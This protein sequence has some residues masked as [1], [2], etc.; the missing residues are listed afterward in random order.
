MHGVE[1]GVDGGVEGLS[2]LVNLVLKRVWVHRQSEDGS[3]VVGSSISGGSSRVLFVAVVIVG[4]AH[5]VSVCV[6]CAC[7]GK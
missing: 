4:V 1:E 2:C 7:G 6:E 5:V 3:T